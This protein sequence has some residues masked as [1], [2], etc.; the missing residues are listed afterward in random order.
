MAEKLPFNFRSFYLV[1]VL[2]VL[3]STIISAQFTDSNLPIVL[4][5]T[6]INPQSGQPEEIVDDPRVPATMKIIKRPDGTR[7]YI[8]DQNT[9]SFLNYNGRISIELRGSTSQIPPKKGYGLTTLEND[10]ATNNNVSLLGMPSEND[11]ILNGFAFD[12]SLMRDYLS[13]NLSSMIGNYAPR[14]QYCEV[15]INGDYR[16]LYLLQEKIKADSNRVNILKITPEDNAGEN[17]TGGYITKA[18]KTTG[19]DPVAWT[20]SSYTGWTEFIHDLPKP[21]EVSPVQDNY[22][23]SVF[24]TLANTSQVHNFGFTDGYPSVID[25]PSFIDFFIINELASNADAYQLSTYFHKDRN[26]KLRAGPVW[27]H[28]LTYGNDLF[29][30]GLDRSHYDVWQFNNGDNN[31][32]KFWKDLFDDPVFSC[33]LSKRYNELI[34]PG[35]PL[36]HNNLVTFIDN[37]VNLISEAV[38]RENARW[39]TIPDHAQEIENMKMFLYLRLQW[40][41]SNIGPYEACAE[42]I[43]PPLVISKINYNPGTS[44]PFPVSNDQEFIE[45][46][47]IGNE[48]IDLTGIYFREL[49]I[50]YQFPDNAVATPG[51]SIY[52]ASNPAVFQNKYGVPAFGQF[53]RN[54][55]NKSQKLALADGFGNIIDFVEYK[56]AAPWPDADGNGSYLQLT[57]VLLDNSLASS[58]TAAPGNTLATSSNAQ[59]AGVSVYPNP[60]TGTLY[61]DSVS[62]ILQT[63]IFDLSGRLVY[64]GKS[65]GTVDFSRFVEGIYLIK[66][67]S[68]E[69]A[70]SIKVVKK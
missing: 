1:L 28:N 24:T 22:I 54:L 53:T 50:T 37:T 38:V 20:M 2:I 57:D 9:T 23:H 30:F 42:Y 55:S 31:G 47:N 70:T 45:I 62:E 58:W 34:A 12:P 32:A 39:G 46:R 44:G 56:D 41:S 33:Y 40:I 68:A 64:S 3:K 8:A 27:D 4:I 29:D 48:E 51:Q 59:H 13:Y 63:E 35:Q 26:G 11:W 49:G 43:A 18:D 15:V 69:G 65:A 14:T 6:D 66:L 17:L 16:G 36:K 61:I 21:E 10:D 7:N 5:T 67:L 52:L 60:T 25:L 19:G